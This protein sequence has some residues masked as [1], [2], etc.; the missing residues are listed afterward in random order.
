MK[1]KHLALI[2]VIALALIVC[3]LVFLI[4]YLSYTGSQS[5]ANAVVTSLFSLLR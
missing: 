3:G 2:I 1:L 5:A 4:S